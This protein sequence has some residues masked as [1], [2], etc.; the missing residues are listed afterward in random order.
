MLRQRVP[1]LSDVFPNKDT[2]VKGSNPLQSQVP[3]G[4]GTASGYGGA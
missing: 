4:D 2:V 1:S 3:R